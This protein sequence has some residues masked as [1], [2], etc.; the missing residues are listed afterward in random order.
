M[1]YAARWGEGENT[2]H[3]MK[4]KFFPSSHT[5]VVHSSSVLFLLSMFILRLKVFRGRYI[6][7]YKVKKRNLRSKGSI[8]DEGE[9]CGR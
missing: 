5:A 1:N 2:T 6:H 3:D 9:G 8:D 7:M 4:V